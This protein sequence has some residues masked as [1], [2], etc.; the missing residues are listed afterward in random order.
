LC[1]EFG[2]H[3]WRSALRQVEV[4]ALAALAVAAIASWRSRSKARSWARMNRAH[5]SPAAAA[6]QR[7]LRALLL[8][9]FIG[10]AWWLGVALETQAG[11]SGNDRYLVLGTALIAI[12]GG[13][14]WGWC[15]HA[16][17]VAAGRIARALRL[18]GMPAG[19]L[20][21]GAGGVAVAAG[22]FLAL[23]PWIGSKVVSV[24]A[25]HG[26]LVYQAHLRQDM[27]KAVTGLGG[28][29][30][31]LRCGTV[32]TEGFQVPM[33][34]WTLDVH[35]VR[36]EAPPASTAHPGLPPNVIFQA[37]ATRR[38]FL[39]PVVKA[40]KNTHYRLVARART[41]SVYSSCAG[42]VTL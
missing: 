23:P 11:F 31:I 22:L 36:V 30:R 25:T 41:F 2:H 42:R 7:A 27:A 6:R 10:F 34:A 28:P 17:T 5:A 4:G 20:V 8:L 21:A 14:G 1:T 16:T 39:L 13:V 35:T 32:M 24:P 18:R 29:A 37:R 12:V 26:A 38:A 19:P 15:A 33:V 9:G 40:W 3:A